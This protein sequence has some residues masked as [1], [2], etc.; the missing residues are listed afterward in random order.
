VQAYLAHLATAKGYSEATLAAYAKDLAQFHAFLATRQA[1]LDDPAAVTKAH[2]RGFLAELH[3]RSTAKSSVGR[4][5][6]A[7]RGFFKH[8]ARRRKIATNPVDGVANPK[9]AKRHPRVIN[10]DQALSLMGAGVGRDPEGLRDMALA[11]LLYGSGL[12]ISEA[13][14]L[15]VID[16]D[17]ESRTLRVLGKGSKERVVPLT[18]P[19]ME[20]LRD[21]IAQRHAFEPDPGEGA[22]FLG[23]R[24]GRLQRRQANRIV[25]R[26]SALAG[27][28]QDISP[29]TLRHAF[30]THLLES[31]ADIRN[32]QELLGHANLT[33][34]TRYTHL[35][36]SR[37]A[38]A[39]DKAHPR[40]KDAEQKKNDGKK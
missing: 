27:I 25:A 15:D 40:A 22:L 16:V 26:L 14:G 13:L 3:R 4:K 36:V 32:V 1:G 10:V 20:R 5:L 34:T 17:P 33:T 24:G 35:T 12:R 19:A 37:L 6:S 9:S 18:E 2:I 21:Y 30:A 29:H 38:H 28:P 8:L 31:G 39:Y 7:L 23:V 11:E